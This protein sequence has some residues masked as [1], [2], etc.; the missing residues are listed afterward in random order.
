MKKIKTRNTQNHQLGDALWPI[1]EFATKPADLCQIGFSFHHEFLTFS[2]IHEALIYPH[3]CWLNMAASSIPGAPIFLRP[4]RSPRPPSGPP[5][6]HPCHGR[7]QWHAEP[8]GFLS[9]EFMGS[10]TVQ[11]S[12]VP[13]GSMG[14]PSSPVSRRWITRVSTCFNHQMYTFVC[15]GF[16]H[17][18]NPN[19]T[20][21]DMGSTAAPQVIHVVSLVISERGN[22][23]GGFNMLPLWRIWNSVG[24]IPAEHS[25]YVWHQRPGVTSG[26]VCVLKGDGPDTSEAVCNSRIISD[27]AENPGLHTA[28]MT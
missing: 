21:S 5:C 17:P 13:W 14:F 1:C 11:G 27:S 22:L 24:I 26:D 9:H 6:V 19:P 15:V 16:D 12:G 3:S 25:K 8:R 4:V 20:R 7:P 10:G 18:M 23:L 28:L 2:Q